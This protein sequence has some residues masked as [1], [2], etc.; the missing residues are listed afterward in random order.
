MD[1]ELVIAR[2]NEN[3]DWLKKVPKN[4]KITI[5]NKG[6]ENISYP[7]TQIPNVGRESNTYLYH[8]IKN[9]NNL[10][11]NTIFCQG[12]PFDHCPKFIK[13]LKHVHKYEKIQP[14]N[15]TLD[16]D[17]SLR[18]LSYITINDEKIHID[19]VNNDFIPCYPIYWYNMNF[20]NYIDDIKKMYKTNNVYKYYQKKLN[21]NMFDSK[22]LIPINYAAIFS[23]HKSLILKNSIQFYKNMNKVLLETTK[24][25]LGYIYERL[26]MIVFGFHKYNSHYKQLTVKEHEAKDKII[27]PKKNINIK[28]PIFYNWFI[29]VFLNNGTKYELGVYKYKLKFKYNKVKDIIKFKNNIQKNFIFKMKKKSNVNTLTIHE[30][31]FSFPKDTYITKIIFY[32]YLIYNF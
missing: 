22:Y 5:Y 31:T 23:V 12:N 26:W 1:V 21:L 9:Y 19:Y 32:N 30:H 18:N 3:L 2:Y 27:Y 17:E 20:E 8:I 28:I 4:I 25:D 6:K 11:K 29:S 13:L 10:S 7:F 24:F 14:L 15:S 16:I